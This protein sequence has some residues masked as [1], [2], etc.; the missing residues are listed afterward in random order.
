MSSSEND[1]TILPL[2]EMYE[3]E[4][5]ITSNFLL[6]DV[7]EEQAYSLLRRHASDSRSGLVVTGGQGRLHGVS[8]NNESVKGTQR[9]AL[10]M[11]A[12]RYKAVLGRYA[13]AASVSRST[14]SLHTVVDTALRPY[15]FDVVEVDNEV[16]YSME[17]FM[18]AVNAPRPPSLDVTP[19]LRHILEAYE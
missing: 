14:M 4:W 12:L 10:E 5:A 11:V 3:E 17:Q 6:A 16:V 18:N 19:H 15:Q 1:P 8:F 13:T 9:S 7:H 2:D